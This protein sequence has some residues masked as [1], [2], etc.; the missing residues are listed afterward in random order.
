MNEIAVFLSDRIVCRPLSIIQYDYNLEKHPK[1]KHFFS[2]PFY[3]LYL[4]IVYDI[5]VK[6]YIVYDIVVNQYY[7]NVN[8]YCYG[9]PDSSLVLTGTLASFHHDFLI[10]VY[11]YYFDY[12]KEINVYLN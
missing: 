8:M 12:E 7:V 4:C 1:A 2:L 5:I 11:V 3:L 10:N 6:Y 9:D